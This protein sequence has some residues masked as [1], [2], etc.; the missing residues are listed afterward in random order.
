M[1]VDTSVLLALAFAEPHAAWAAAQLDANAGDLCMSTVNLAEVL[2]HLRDRRPDAIA[3]LEERVLTL[4]LRYVPPS[5]E[6]ARVAAE[7][8]L[9]YPLNLGDCFAYALAVEQGTSI[10]TLDTDFRAVDRP[11]VMPPSAEGRNAP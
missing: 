9:R 7:A 5:V 8:R 11:V 4:G 2:I 10:L 3:E 6:Q 1:V